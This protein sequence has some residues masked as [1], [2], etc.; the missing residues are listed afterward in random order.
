MLQANIDGRFP[1]EL[2]KL[3]AFVG[4]PVLRATQEVCVFKRD[5]IVLDMNKQVELHAALE[6][7]RSEKKM[8]QEKA[9]A[10]IQE[11]EDQARERCKVS[12]FTQNT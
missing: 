10:V 2:S 6:R 12:A 4:G 1:P 9:L 7:A 3:G 5:F 8:E 11:D